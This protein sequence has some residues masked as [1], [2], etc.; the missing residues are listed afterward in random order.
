MKNQNDMDF[1]F[2][3]YTFDGIPAFRL[4]PLRRR[5]RR[6]F[7]NLIQN[8]RIRLKSVSECACSNT[9]FYPI[10]FK[11]RFG[12][13]FNN[14]MCDRCGLLILNPQMTDDS[15]EVYYKEIYHPL[16]VGTPKGVLLDDLVY[17]RQGDVI[18]TFT[19]K[20]INSELINVCEVG[21]A[22]GNN[23]IVFRDSANQKGIRCKLYGCEFEDHYVSQAR[24]RGIQITNKGTESLVSFGVK[25]DL[26]ILSHV[27]EHFTDL[28]KELSIL[29]GV[30]SNEGLL[31]IEVPGLMNLERYNSDLIDYLVH[32]HNY[33]FNLASLRNVLVS[34][35]FALVNGNE[36][37]QGLFR[38][39]KNN[40][41]KRSVSN[42]PECIL[43]FLRSTES[44]FNKNITCKTRL[45]R[46]VWR[47]LYRMEY[48]LLLKKRMTMTK[49]G[50]A[51]R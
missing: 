11:D 14:Q 36:R 22:G 24:Q 15:L 18:F 32:A 33:N 31:Y 47:L 39:E 10:A 34:N 38:I 51:N 35:G 4:N 46:S 3:R 5:Y 17:E 8:D 9:S 6:K 20:C 26:I 25:F 40:R 21:C 41:R 12:L 37:V 43:Q 50:F 28:E 7:L 16:V 45:K 19:H 29:K 1:H 27:F 42:N 49:F 13:P 30:L 2:K 44:A 48:L 23:L